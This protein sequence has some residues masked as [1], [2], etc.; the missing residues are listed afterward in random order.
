MER[1]YD[2]KEKDLP[3]EPEIRK[4][5]M[6]EFFEHER[7]RE[8]TG[9][10]S[11]YRVL[12]EG[13]SSMM[14]PEN[15]TKEEEKQLIEYLRSMNK[16]RKSSSKKFVLIAGWREDMDREFDRK[17]TEA[18]G[19]SP[20]GAVP[21]E[22]SEKGKPEIRKV[23][24]QEFFDQERKR[25]EDGLPPTKYRKTLHEGP[26]SVMIP[27]G[28]TEEQE[29]QLL[30]HIREMNKEQKR[31]DEEYHQKSKQWRGPYP[32]EAREDEDF[33][34]GEK[35]SSAKHPLLKRKAAVESLEEIAQRYPRSIGLAKSSDPGDYGSYSDL[36]RQR[37]PRLQLEKKIVYEVLTTNGP[38]VAW[39]RLG[40]V[41]PTVR[42]AVGGDILAA[43]EKSR[44]NIYKA[45]DKMGMFGTKSD[46]LRHEGDRYY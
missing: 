12:H 24:L 32:P 2:Q 10:P 21:P 33:Y 20:K 18:I 35:E 37:N 39:D 16:M 36:Q 7:R 40:R 25:E 34:S 4:V 11:K 1:E 5:P 9:Q 38:D 46:S 29:Q 6:Q 19:E 8:E 41:V 23:P 17:E 43:Y 30:E 45:L 22:F 3:P 14:I 26:S 27:E 42:K 44:S 28:M 15:T 31:K 13:R